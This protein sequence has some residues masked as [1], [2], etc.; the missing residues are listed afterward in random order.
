MG[1]ETTTSMTITCDNPNCP[2]NSLDPA[3]Y[4][5]WIQI[6]ATT[7]TSAEFAIPVPLPSAIY[8]SPACAGTIEEPLAAAEEAR[9][10]PPDKM[11]DED[12]AAT[13]SKTTRSRDK[14]S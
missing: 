4:V 2:G 3:S 7:V 13:E 11:P 14:K 1:V 12:E 9:N 6:Q 5:G 8:C 10:A